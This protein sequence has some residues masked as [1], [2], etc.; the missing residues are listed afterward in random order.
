MHCGTD[1]WTQKG[2]RRLRPKICMSCR[3]KVGR[4][5]QKA[6]AL[7]YSQTHFKTDKGKEE[8]V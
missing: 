7:S 5:A 6:Q 3:T 8:V 4:N 2:E 1:Y